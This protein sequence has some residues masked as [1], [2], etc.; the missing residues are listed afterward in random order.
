[1]RVCGIMGLAGIFGKS[2]MK[3]TK[4]QP[5]RAP[6]QG[7]KSTVMLRYLHVNPLKTGLD[8]NYYDPGQLWSDQSI[9]V[10]LSSYQNTQT[11]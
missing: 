7:D 2:K 4:N 6:R 1:M 11:G 10:L 8:H 5:V 3:E 9:T